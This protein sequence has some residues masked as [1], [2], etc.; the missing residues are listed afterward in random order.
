MLKVRK[1]L[2]YINT[3]NSPKAAPEGLLF[4]ATHPIRPKIDYLY[5][6]KKFTLEKDT[7]AQT[8]QKSMP[9]L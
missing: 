8:D 2:L 3:M 7:A 4:F 1:Q 9:N 6:V 5:I